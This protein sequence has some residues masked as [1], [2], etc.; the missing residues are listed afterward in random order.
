[1]CVF[2]AS[3]IRALILQFLPGLVPAQSP[4]SE[5][6]RFQCHQRDIF[7]LVVLSA[8][9]FIYP[10]FSSRTKKDES[11]FLTLT[12]PRSWFQKSNF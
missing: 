9:F 6:C 5:I 7:Q 11:W 2:S 3:T 10:E 1:M 12:Q 8:E 4:R